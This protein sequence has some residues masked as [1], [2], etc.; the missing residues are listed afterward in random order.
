MKSTYRL[1]IIP[2]LMIIFS[3]CNTPQ[4]QP[5]PTTE[6]IAKPPTASPTF[7]GLVEITINGIGTQNLTSSAKML[8]GVQPTGL[9]EQS[10]VNF[11]ESKFVMTLRSVNTFDYNGKRYISANYGISN[12]YPDTIDSLNFVAVDNEQTFGTTPLKNIQKFNG[13]PVAEADITK[14][15]FQLAP[16]HRFNSSTGQAELEYVQ[17][18]FTTFSA[19]SLKSMNFP[20]GVKALAMGYEAKALNRKYTTIFRDGEVDPKTF[21]GQVNFTTSY[22]VQGATKDPFSFTFV[23][24]LASRQASGVSV[25]GHL[26]D[27]A[28]GNNIQDEG[29]ANLDRRVVFL[30]DNDNGQ[31]DR[32]EY[33]VVSDKDG[34]YSFTNVPLGEHNVR[35]VIPF[36][37]RN[38]F[39]ND[40]KN[41]TVQANAGLAN[42][43]VLPRRL[44]DIVQQIA[45]RRLDDVMPNVVGGRDTDIN[46]YPFMLALGSVREIQGQLAFRQFCGAT[47]ISDRFAVTA[48]HCVD[49]LPS[50]GANVGVL[51]NTTKLSESNTGTI[52]KIKRITMHPNYISADRGYDVA[53]LELEQPLPLSKHTYTVALVDEQHRHWTRDDVV[54]TI[55]GWGALASGGQ[56][57]DH[58]KV[59]HSKIV[60]PADCESAYQAIGVDVENF[61]TQI[62]AGVPEGGVDAC[63]GDSGGPLFVRGVLDGEAQWFHAGATSWGTGCAAPGLAGIWAR[64]SVLEPWIKEHAREISQAHRV[65]VMAGQNVKGLNFANRSTLRP[66]IGDI[67][68]RWQI[69]NFSNTGGEGVFVEADKALTFEWNIFAE[70]KDFNYSC[71]VSIQ[72][73]ATDAAVMKQDVPCKLGKNSYTFSKGISKDSYDIGLSVA[74]NGLRYERNTYIATV[75]SLLSGELATSDYVLDPAEVGE[76]TLYTDYYTFSGADAGDTIFIQ[77]DSKAFNYPYIFL[78]DKDTKTKPE[79]INDTLGY[80]ETLL[81][82]KVEKGK[83][84]L[85]GV[86]SAQDRGVGAYTLTLSK[87]SLQPFTFPKAQVQQ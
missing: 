56:S 65:K 15:K 7:L 70:T 17:N 72:K 25:E 29:E 12:H 52:S 84:Y 49:G 22:E 30:D 6:P 3:A 4:V 86:T 58:L 26:W 51:S 36:G 44:E 31:L 48:S 74:A 66:M 60:N 75:A 42:Y 55:T 50:V 34:N 80:N 28:N 19:D 59:V 77:M 13:E 9:Q 14:G 63:Q 79:S 64:T 24:A 67:P 83:N 87:G 62:C 11:D 47:L 37:E 39:I 71:E 5:E 78:Y 54:A 81:S 85:I 57:P 8:S 69:T 38:T 46:N 35:Q 76:V 33:R 53:V 20:K 73:L 10:L 16:Y 82:F 45:D 68:S 27:D 41:S 23:F 1:M 32:F 21:E 18:D 43:S 40:P 61:D 2:L